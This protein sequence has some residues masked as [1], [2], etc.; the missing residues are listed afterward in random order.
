MYST[1]GMLVLL[2]VCVTAC[3]SSP[4]TTSPPCR[5]EGGDCSPEAARARVLAAF[6]DFAVAEVLECVSRPSYS[7]SSTEPD[8][9][10]CLVQVKP[11]ALAT[12]P[13]VAEHRPT[14]STVVGWM[15]RLKKSFQT[16]AIDNTRLIYS[17]ED[18][19]LVILVITEERCH[20]LHEVSRTS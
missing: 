18:K 7:C 17:D 5:V 11:A 19:S 8:E 10:A 20:N 6:P 16:V 15:G 12:Y 4:T 1:V 14:P 3:T 13:L 2:G 9:E